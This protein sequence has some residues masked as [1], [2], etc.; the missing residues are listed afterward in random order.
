[1]MNCST[2]NGDG[3]TTD[4][5]QLCSTQNAKHTVVDDSSEAIVRS[6]SSRCLGLMAIV[7]IL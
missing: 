2:S 3:S 5:I 6:P 1:M 4:L 7:T